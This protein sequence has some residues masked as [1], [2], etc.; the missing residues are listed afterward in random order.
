MS[1][2]TGEYTGRIFLESAKQGISGVLV[3]DGFQVVRTDEDGRYCLS[4]IEK[5]VKFISVTVPAGYRAE[6]FYQAVEEEGENDF[7]LQHWNASGGSDF[8]FIHISDSETS[9]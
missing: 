3:S 4:K 9:E 8:S 5:R 7:H 1:D 6:R 2:Q